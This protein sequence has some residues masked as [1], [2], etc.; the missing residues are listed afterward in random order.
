MTASTVPD[1]AMPN[2][3][4]AELAPALALDVPVLPPV[5]Q[6]A[7]GT[8]AAA[9]KEPVIRVRR[10]NDVFS[11]DSPQLAPAPAEQQRATGQKLG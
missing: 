3:L 2:G 8:N 5:A 9:A 7:N 4:S 10:P 1:A 6:D 11:I